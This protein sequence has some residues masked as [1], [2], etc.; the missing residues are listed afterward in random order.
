MGN[1]IQ[2]SP[3]VQFRRLCNFRNDRPCIKQKK[4]LIG[5]FLVFIIMTTR[6]FITNISSDFFSSESL[7]LY[8]IFCPIYQRFLYLTVITIYP[9]LLFI[10]SPLL[11]FTIQSIYSKRQY[12]HNPKALRC[13]GERPSHTARQRMCS[14]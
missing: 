4:V 11:I 2:F 1:C 5:M 12:I 3:C 9:I 10:T 14:I 6:C 7:L 8:S 13:F